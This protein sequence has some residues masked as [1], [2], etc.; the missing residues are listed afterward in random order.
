MAEDDKN[1]RHI[2][3]IANTDLD[4]KKPI[5]HALRKIRGIGFM[6]ANVLC[7]I[8]GIEKSKTTGHLSDAESKKLDDILKDPLKYNI[9]VWMFNRR[10]DYDTGKDRHLI[11]GDIKFNVE[12]DIKMMRMIKSYK[13]MRHSLGLPVR[14]QLTKSNFRRNK[15]KVLGVKRSKKTGKT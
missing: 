11:T 12:N 2:V 5:G 15:G 7:N 10:K 8:A 13:G 1:F 3:R 4:G 9:P 6:F 14:G